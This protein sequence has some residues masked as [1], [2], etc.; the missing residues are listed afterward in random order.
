MLGV[1]TVGGRRLW[2]ARGRSG[3]CVCV[4]GIGAQE[5]TLRAV[6]HE[7]KQH[8]DEIERGSAPAARSLL[9]SSLAL[10]LVRMIRAAAGATA[11]SIHTYIPM[12]REA[13]GL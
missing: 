6:Q 10:E 9:T 12:Q 2:V 7:G 4:A 5:Q 8:A 3:R 13:R 11:Y 1:R